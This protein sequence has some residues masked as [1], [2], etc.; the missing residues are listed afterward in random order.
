MVVTDLA[1]T[2]AA[3]LSVIVV[4]I[5][6]R[7]LIKILEK[8]IEGSVSN[9][10]LLSI[11]GLNMIT[12]A[13]TFLPVSL[14]MAVLM[15]LGRMYREQ[16][17]SAIFSAGGGAGT[18]YRSVLLLVM[19]LTVASAGL[20]FYIGP[21]AEATVQQLM[22]KDEKTAG[23][24]GISAGRF[25]EYQQ[26][27]LVFY[28]ESINKDKKMQQVFVQH[29]RGGNLAIVNADTGWLEN[30]PEGLYMVL[31][32]GQ[33]VQG[34]LGKTHYV[35]EEFDQYG[36]RLEEKDA[37]VVFD[38]E[39]TTT[40]MLWGSS[41]IKDI[42]ELQRRFSIP[43]GVLF[44]SLLAV[45]LA[46]TS[47]RTGVFGN[48]LTAFLIYFS[49]GNLVRVSHSWV[50]KGQIPVWLGGFWLYLFLLI[51]TGALLIKF[52]GWRFVRLKISA[53]VTR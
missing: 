8:V 49:Y 46:Q 34:V 31:A 16:E 37:T 28:V 13:I 23:V 30:R 47:P 39:A 11:V 19:P 3:V 53:K 9:E 36:I 25:S 18:L 40:G 17:M 26:G 51:V 24:R 2:L 1:R 50:V 52:Y 44:L 21:W 42:A 45:P 38:Q 29:R 35:V 12:A 6:S 20:S 27:D 33:R 41:V 15:V 10:T 48:L 5:V 14:F 4:I 32:Q 22:L 7:K 43:A